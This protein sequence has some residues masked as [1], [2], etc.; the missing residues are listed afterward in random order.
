M[1]FAGDLVVGVWVGN[2]DNSPMKGV[3]G[4][5]MPAAMWHEFMMEALPEVRQI[6]ERQAEE[7]R[8]REEADAAAQVDLSVLLGP[9]A[10]AVMRGEQIDVARAA[11]LLGQLGNVIANTP[12]DAEGIRAAARA[13]S[14]RINKAVTEDAPAE[15]PAT[16]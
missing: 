3:L 16:P 4:S 15:P 14:D 2:D 12:E 6:S 5:T 7:R 13:L 9:D 1:G 10:E 11:A 8:A